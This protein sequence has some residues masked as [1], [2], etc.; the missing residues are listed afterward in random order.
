MKPSDILLRPATPLTGTFKKTEAEQ[1]A[2]P[3]PA[4][5]L[6]RNDRYFYPLLD[7]PVT[8]MQTSRGCPYSCGYFCPYPAVQGTRWRSRSPSHV[9]TEIADCVENHG[10]RSILFRDATFTLNK[11]RTHQ[12]C[13]AISERDYELN[14]WCE[15]RVDCLD[16][17][18]LDAMKRAGCRGINV[19]VETGNE[20]I[21][22]TQA[23]VGLTLPK[24]RALRG[25]AEDLG[26]RLHFLLIVG[27]PNETRKTIYDTYQL[28]R[29]L[30][31]ET[32]GVTVITPYPGTPLYMEAKSKGWIET[33][34]WSQYDGHVPTMHTDH[35][36]SDE[37]AAARKW[38]HRGFSLA[39]RRDPW[40]RLKRHR[41]DASF[42][43]W[44]QTP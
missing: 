11:K 18:V 31:P 39:K 25:M 41:H 10:L 28:I 17:P 13:E 3:V 37:I 33:E 35:L 2:T 24:L 6:L 1:G 38:M 34:D 23:K 29:E 15:T 22:H 7:G 26:I 36:R 19:G 9:L 14:W 40:G 20:E 44:A 30:D 4:R 32:I 8:T 12:I 5:Q 21:M 27:L 43:E 42:R 16:R